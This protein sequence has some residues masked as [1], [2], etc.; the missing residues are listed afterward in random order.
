MA[1]LDYHFWLKTPFLYMI[2]WFS[3]DDEKNRY[4]TE[5]L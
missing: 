1:G 5:M 3:D 4:H 2:S